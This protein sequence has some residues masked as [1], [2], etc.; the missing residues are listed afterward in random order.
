MRLWMAVLSL[1]LCNVV[2][3]ARADHFTIDLG[4][5]AGKV[6]QTAHAEMAAIGVKPKERAILEV[7]AGERISV[8][9]ALASAAPKE[10][11]KDVTVHFFVVKE[12]KA[13]QQIV[14]KLDRDVIAESA[15]TMDFKPKDKTKGELSFTIE[16]AGAYLL[17]LET[18]GAAAGTDGHEHFAALDL[19][20]R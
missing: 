17:R 20:V 14:P 18:I 15:L 7:K 16:K 4:V 5:Q 11:V 19:V 9:W 2:G 10:T 12:E 3:T 6:S 1:L 8:K 13:G